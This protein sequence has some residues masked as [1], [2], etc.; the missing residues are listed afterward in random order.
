[1]RTGVSL[2]RR[3]IARPFGMRTGLQKW[4][5]GA[6]RPGTVGRLSH[7]SEARFGAPN[8]KLDSRISSEVQSGIDISMIDYAKTKI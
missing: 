4:L 7:I 1:M 3:F 5:E 2:R 8:A 6:I